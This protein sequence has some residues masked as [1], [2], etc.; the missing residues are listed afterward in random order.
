ML[1]SPMTKEKRASKSASPAGKWVA[2]YTKPSCKVHAPV[3]IVQ[4]L[5]HI[6]FGEDRVFG[7]WQS[8]IEVKGAYQSALEK[9]SANRPAAGSTC[10]RLAE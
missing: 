6:S 4:K 7:D 10:R 5:S 1:R 8:T 2:R 3:M 9:K